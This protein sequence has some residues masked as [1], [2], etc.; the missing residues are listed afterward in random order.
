MRCFACSPAHNVSSS[1][2][3]TGG[4]GPVSSRIEMLQK[5]IFSPVSSNGPQKVSFIVCFLD[6][7]LLVLS[8]AVSISSPALVFGMCRARGEWVSLVS[9]FLKSGFIQR[10]QISPRHH[11]SNEVQLSPVTETT[12]VIIVGVCVACPP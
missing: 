2:G 12:T 5:E 8:T 11:M 6:V 1:P 4:A 3:C 9:C 10:T 7:F